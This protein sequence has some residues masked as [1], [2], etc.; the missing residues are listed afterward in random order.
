MGCLGLT[1][2][3]PGEMKGALDRAFTS[4]RP[5]IIDVKSHIDGIAPAA[6]VPQ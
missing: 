6:W 3:Q 4:G 2:R 1:V 5:T